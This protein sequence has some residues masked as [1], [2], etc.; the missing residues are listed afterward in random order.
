MAKMIDELLSFISPLAELDRSYE[1]R[2][3]NDSVI[4]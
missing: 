2:L 1:N 4:Y 3:L